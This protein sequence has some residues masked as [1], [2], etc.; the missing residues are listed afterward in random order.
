MWNNEEQPL[1]I[2]SLLESTALITALGARNDMFLIADCRE[3]KDFLT[4][5]GTKDTKVFW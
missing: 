3:P 4:T 2:A 5:K 1:E